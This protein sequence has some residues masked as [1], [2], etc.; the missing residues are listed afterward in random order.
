MLVLYFYPEGNK[1][2]YKSGLSVVMNF[3]IHFQKRRTEIKRVFFVL[4]CFFQH[5]QAVKLRFVFAEIGAKGLIVIPKSQHQEQG[6]CCEAVHHAL[7]VSRTSYS[8]CCVIWA[9]KAWNSA[10][11]KPSRK[12]RTWLSDVKLLSQGQLH[13]SV[14]AWLYE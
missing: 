12:V 3:L 1:A 9:V 7:H 2:K 6:W 11:L 13:V 10:V 4:F 8:V 14:I 5:R